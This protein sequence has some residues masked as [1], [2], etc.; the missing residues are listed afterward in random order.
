MLVGHVSRIELDQTSVSQPLPGDDCLDDQG[1]LNVASSF[2][3]AVLFIDS[4]ISDSCRPLHHPSIPSLS[5]S[6]NPPSFTPFA[7][8]V[9]VWTRADQTFLFNVMHVRACG[10]PGC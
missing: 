3:F 1:R 5:S 6:S 9:L 2:P 8:F 7:E 4:S 10:W